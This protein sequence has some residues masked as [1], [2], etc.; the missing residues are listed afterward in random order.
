[1]KKS[2]F[3]NKSIKSFL[4]F[5]S[6]LL[7]TSLFISAIPGKIIGFEKT[8]EYIS[9]KGIPDPIASI[10]LVGAIVCLILG[11]GFFIFGENQKIGSVFLL[12]FIIPTTI[13]FHVFP[14][15]QRAVLM[16]LVLI[17]ALINAALREPK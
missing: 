11:S 4:D 6:R 12:L 16:N 7:I 17:G 5:F 3:K 1:M 10:L 14:F 15:H 2:I 8:V 9:S 13:I